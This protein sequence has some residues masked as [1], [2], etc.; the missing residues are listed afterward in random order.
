MRILIVLILIFV[1]YYMVRGLLRPRRGER[2][3]RETHSDIPRT[4]GTELV[5]D[6]YCQTYVPMRTALQARVGGEDLFFCSEACRDRY[7]QEKRGRSSKAG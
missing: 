6:P 3:T 5:K 2:N 4:G 1:L 7:L